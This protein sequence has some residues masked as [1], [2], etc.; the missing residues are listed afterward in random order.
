MGLLK[1]E[2]KILNYLIDKS[3]ITGLKIGE[4]KNIWRKRKLWKNV[5][6]TKAQKEKL[7]TNFIN[8]FGRKYSDKWHRLYQSYTGRFDENYFPEI[9]FSTKLEPILNSRSISNV[10]QDKNLLETLYGSVEGIRIP[11]TLIG[12][13][14]GTYYVDAG[15][16]RKIAD[17]QSVCELIKNTEKVV[18]KP[19]VG[20]S[21][22]K[23]VKICKFHDGID[24]Y[25]GMP[26]KEILRPYKENFVIQECIENCIELKA[27]HDD[28]VNTL[29]IVTYILDGKLHHLPL[30]LRIGCNG[31]KVDNG[32]A[33]G[34]G[35]GLSDE[36]YLNEYAFT[37]FEKYKEH[38]NS[39]ITF[40]HYL[41]PNVPKAIHMAC[42]CHTKT[43]QVK[44]IS[45]DITIDKDLEVVL[46]EANMFGQSIWPPQLLHGLSAFGKNTS[47]MLRIISRK[48]H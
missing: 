40:H 48:N 28:S 14:Y 44:M 18:I 26:A 25:T 16:K 20:T 30:A 19:A 5:K 4:Y 7:Q 10:L 8:Y 9:L 32:H 17:F 42:L 46:I 38:P 36:G 1:L 27:L 29:R 34:L 21:S 37:E 11:K 3:F 45:W 39:K 41:I 43:P 47:K 31:N 22:G 15:S 6:L 2:R 24:E 33:G 12:N 23:G 13:S 35:I